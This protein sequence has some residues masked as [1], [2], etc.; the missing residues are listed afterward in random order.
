MAAGIYRYLPKEHRL[1]KNAGGD[2]RKKLAR[3]AD[4][5]SVKAV[6]QLPD[7]VQPLILM[8]IGNKTKK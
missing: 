7:D 1:I 5:E 2:Q 3:A 8:P 4:D 6:L